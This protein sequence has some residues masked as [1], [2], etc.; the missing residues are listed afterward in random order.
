MIVGLL[1]KRIKGTLTAEYLPV[2]YRT[3]TRRSQLNQLEQAEYDMIVNALN[4]CGGNKRDAADLL[5]MARSTLYRKLSAYGLAGN[6][7]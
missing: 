4:Q 1:A 5:G 2:A 6:P 7:T 3:F